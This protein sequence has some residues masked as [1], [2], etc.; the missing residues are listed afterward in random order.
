MLRKFFG[1][2]SE[3]YRVRITQICSDSAGNFEW[4]QGVN[5][6]GYSTQHLIEGDLS[7]HLQF[8]LELVE[9]DERTVHILSNFDK[10]QLAKRALDTVNADIHSMTK[11]EFDRK[12][13]IQ[14]DSS[15]VVDTSSKD[16]ADL[17][18]FE[19]DVSSAYETYQNG[20]ENNGSED[21]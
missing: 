10:S 3:F 16:R 4:E 8:R 5:Y 13:L 9:L 2:A 6:S 18:T 15:V 21:A 11:N 7:S 17:E 14:R 19:N 12:Y 1:E 20:M